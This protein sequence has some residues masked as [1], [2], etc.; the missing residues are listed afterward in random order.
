MRALRETGASLPG[1]PPPEVLVTAPAV[2]A[3]A[4][5]AAAGLAG[6][7]QGPDS[8]RHNNKQQGNYNDISQYSGHNK[9]S[10]PG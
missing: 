5:T 8:Q 1:P 10:F 3:V 7:P 9:H 2:S 4:V 6:L